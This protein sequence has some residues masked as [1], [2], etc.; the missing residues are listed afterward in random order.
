ME[1]A[2]ARTTQSL[3]SVQRY[4]HG[5]KMVAVSH[6][7]RTNPDSVKQKENGSFCFRKNSKERNPFI[8]ERLKV[9]DTKFL[10][11]LSLLS[12]ERP[13]FRKVRE[14]E[15]STQDVCCSLTIV[16]F[17]FLHSLR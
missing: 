10:P 4:L 12:L 5:L 9:I 14:V 15:S 7:K 11:K 1:Q 17:I 8:K 6:P 13:L 16:K 2:V 3:P